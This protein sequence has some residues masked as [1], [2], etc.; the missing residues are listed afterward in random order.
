LLIGD[1]ERLPRGFFLVAVPLQGFCS[2]L[3]A[4][5][6][7]ARFVAL[8]RPVQPVPPASTTP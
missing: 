2:F 4:L 5:V 8:L 3:F 7:I 6:V 1:G